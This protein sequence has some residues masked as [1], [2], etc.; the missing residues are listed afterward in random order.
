MVVVLA[1]KL[2]LFA[3]KTKHNLDSVAQ[4]TSLISCG[5]FNIFSLL[6]TF[7]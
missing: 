4:V 7:T 1:A 5:D 2:L 6:T 3:E